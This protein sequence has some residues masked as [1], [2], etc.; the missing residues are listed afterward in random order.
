LVFQIFNN[1]TFFHL[2]LECGDWDQQY[3]EFEPYVNDELLNEDF[4]EVLEALLE[5]IDGGHIQ[6][7]AGDGD[8]T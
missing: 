8:S 5:P 3:T 6:L 2:S 4:V 7:N 1:R